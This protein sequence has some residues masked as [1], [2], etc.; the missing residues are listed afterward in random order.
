MASRNV[1]YRLQEAVYCYEHQLD[2]GGVTVEER[3]NKVVQLL[4]MLQVKGYENCAIVVACINEINKVKEG[5]NQIGNS[6]S[7]SRA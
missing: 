1:P 7:E 3:L 5:V 2:R 6:N 4:N